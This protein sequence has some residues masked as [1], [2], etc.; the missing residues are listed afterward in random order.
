MTFRNILTCC[1][2][3]LSLN[4][5][6]QDKIQIVSSASMFSDMAANLATDNFEIKTI[7]PIGGDPHKYRAKP[8]DARMVQKADIILVNGLTFEGW[9]NELVENSGTKGDVV[10][11]TK[12]VDVI[13][14][15]QYENS[16]DPHAWMDASNGLIYI[17]N[18]K[19]ILIAKSPSDKVA[20]EKNYE[21]YKA[22]LIALDKEIETSIASIPE[23]QNV[24][25]TSHDAFQYYGTR[26]NLRLEAI[27]GISTEAEA[28]TSDIQRVAKVLQEN[29]VPAVFIESTINPKML[30]QIA[31]DNNVAIGG[32]LFA[33]SL[34]DEKSPASTYINMLR[35]NTNTIVQALSK[36]KPIEVEKAE[37]KTKIPSIDDGMSKPLKIALGII[38]ILAV[39]T[40]FVSKMKRS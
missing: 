13:K 37:D 10:T 6:A 18:I 22:K 38:L 31:K 35:S 23:G 33:D 24:L 8:S 30:K 40:V 3:L 25:I 39:V 19:E 12:G 36:T 16:S 34:G 5:A 11:I 1:A 15:M 4:L 14:S 21:S 27:M 26:Y 20:I 32:E 28:Q 17:K 7:V 9:I 29:K 2:L